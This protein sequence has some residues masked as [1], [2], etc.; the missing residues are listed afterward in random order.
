VLNKVVKADYHGAVFTGRTI[1][2]GIEHLAFINM[3]SLC[4]VTQSKSI[5]FV[6]I[7]GIMVKETE[8]MFYIIN[9]NDELKGLQSFSTDIV[10]L[11]FLVVFSRG[12]KDQQ[13]FLFC[14]QGQ[15]FYCLWKSCERATG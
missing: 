14:I 13:H 2:N 6:G 9:R 8:N 11:S 12:S 7:S 3:H 4:L 1:H 5:K 10:V 15:S